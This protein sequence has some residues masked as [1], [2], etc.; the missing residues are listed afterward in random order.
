[1]RL[2]GLEPGT[3]YTVSLWEQSG[4]EANDKT[5]NCD[6]RGGDELMYA[7]LSLDT[8]YVTKQEDFFG[9]ICIIKKREKQ[10]P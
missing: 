5:Y 2:A 1:L 8:T 9:E 4:F 6:L 3:L 10:K 7:G